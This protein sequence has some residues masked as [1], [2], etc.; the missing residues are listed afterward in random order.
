MYWLSKKELYGFTRRALRFMRN[1]PNELSLDKIPGEV[2]SSKK[3]KR[4]YR[5]DL[6]GLWND[7]ASETI[8][9]DYRYHLIPALIHELL[10]EFHPNWTEQRVLQY[11]RWVVRGLSK[12]QI[13]NLLKQFADCL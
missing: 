2:V 3:Y 12:K 4:K 10:H 11:E 1:H 8:I 9:V 5:I 7:D 13:V 6:H